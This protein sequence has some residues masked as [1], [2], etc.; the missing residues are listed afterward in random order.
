MG[1]RFVQNRKSN[2]T[3]ELQVDRIQVACHR[4]EIY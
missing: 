4:D 3:S 1:E 2:D